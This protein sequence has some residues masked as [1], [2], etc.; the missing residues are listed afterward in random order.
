MLGGA[1]AFRSWPAVRWLLLTGRRAWPRVGIDKAEEH[2]LVAFSEAGK[3]PGASQSSAS[4]MWPADGV[5]GEAVTSRGCSARAAPL[6]VGPCSPSGCGLGLESV[7]RW[8]HAPPLLAQ[9]WQTRRHRGPGRLALGIGET[10][11]ASW[12]QVP[13]TT[14]RAASRY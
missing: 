12:R 11:A 8:Q 10:L 1:L 9:S 6:S 13:Q 4:A 3:Q 5:R 14:A 2:H 7:R